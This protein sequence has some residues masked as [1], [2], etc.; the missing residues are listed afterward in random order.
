MI[1]A[2]LL[3]AVLATACGDAKKSSARDESIRDHR[4]AS[5]A[6]P[7]SP[8]VQPAPNDAA[9][10]AVELDAAP[11]PSEAELEAERQEALLRLH[12]HTGHDAEDRE[13]MKRRLEAARLAAARAQVEEARKIKEARATL[14]SD[15]KKLAK[16]DAQLSKAITN[17][18]NAKSAA[19]QTAATKQLDELRAQRAELVKS[20][21]ALRTEVR[22]YERR[23]SKECLDNPLAKGC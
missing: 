18:A 17:V 22:V 1:R 14:K 3:L 2:W 13:E 8:V 16:L 20:V 9:P 6:A 5:P 12:G 19:D 23:T 11:E 7:P 10:A 15:E 4:S 21:E